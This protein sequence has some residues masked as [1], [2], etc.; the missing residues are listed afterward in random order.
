MV[1]ARLLVLIPVLSIIVNRL[2]HQSHTVVTLKVFGL[3]CRRIVLNTAG[4]SLFYW[5]KGLLI[6]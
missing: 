5:D 6:L 4:P 2:H 1:R 3:L